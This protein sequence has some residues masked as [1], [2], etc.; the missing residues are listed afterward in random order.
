[1]CVLFILLKIFS[2]IVSSSSKKQKYVDSYIVKYYN[3]YQNFRFAYL[4]KFVRFAYFTVVWACAL[5]FIELTN[6][7]REFSIWNSVLCIVMFVLFVGY[8]IAGFIYLKWRSGYQSEGTFQ[9]N[10]E[11]VRVDRGRLWH[12]IWRYY[13]LL[14]IALLIALVYKGNPLAILIPLIIVHIVDGLIIVGFKPFGLY[15]EPQLNVCFYNSYPQVYQVTSALQSFLFAFLEL[16]ILIMYAVRDKASN[17]SYLGLG[18]F[19]CAIVVALLANG[20]VRL[21]WGFIKIVEACFSRSK[22]MKLQV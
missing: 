3:D 1:M 21:V 19:C 16:F 7:P 14:V 5:Q 2:H 11:D 22:E 4:D 6:Q 10:F 15:Q 9:K 8:P 12:F 13:R 20:L 18:Y 17:Y